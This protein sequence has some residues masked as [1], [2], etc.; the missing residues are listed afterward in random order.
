MVNIER[1]ICSIN[2][3]IHVAD[4][5]KELKNKQVILKCMYLD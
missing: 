1:T 3:T 2:L 5:W 4:E